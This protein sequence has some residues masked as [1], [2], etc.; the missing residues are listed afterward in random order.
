MAEQLIKRSVYT[1]AGELIRS[2][3][4]PK[5]IENKRPVLMKYWEEEDRRVANEEALAAEAAAQ[6]SAQ[7]PEPSA[8][9]LVTPLVERLESAES[10]LGILRGLKQATPEFIL[11]GVHQI[12][13]AAGASAL[14]EAA[15][16]TAIASVDAAAAGAQALLKKIDGQVG[17]T[18]NA[19]GQMLT[20][21]KLSLARTQDEMLAKTTAAISKRIAGLEVQASQLKGPKGSTGGVGIGMVCGVGPK[22]ETRPD[23]SPWRVGDS[24]LRTD[25]DGLALQYLGPDGWSKAQKVVPEPR[26]IN[27]VSNTYDAAPRQATTIVQSGSASSGG[28]GQE[29]LMTSRQGGNVDF[30]LADSSNYGAA[31]QLI[32]G[33]EITLRLVSETSGLSGLL[34]AAFSLENTNHFSYT[35][36]SQVGDLF[37]P[38][39][40]FSV[41]LAG[42]HQPP[43]IPAGITAGGSPQQALVIKARINGPGTYQ[44]TG[45]VSW[46]LKGDGIVVPK[47]G[48]GPQPAWVWA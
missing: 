19:I 33:G 5:N 14:V 4:V 6:E 27:A 45:G 38:P 11:E 8:E 24:Y 37:L 7:A 17:E 48:A 39:S 46:T 28:G 34:V 22:G 42:S 47:G 9:D 23:K 21:S 1:D 25:V 12:A 2:G 31:G 29:R 18:A 16:K 32:S 3:L 26:L 44:I 15:A 13:R 20:D 30:V 10:E 41:D 40:T 43:T 36:F 35:D